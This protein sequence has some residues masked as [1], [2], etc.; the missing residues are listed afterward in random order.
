MTTGAQ[1]TTFITGLNGGASID[2]TLL[3]VLVST[4][5]AILEAERPWMPLRKMNTAL[6][7][8][9]SNTWQTAKA[10][11]SI[12]DFSRFYGDGFITLYDGSNARH[13]YRQVPADRQLEYKDDNTA[14]WYDVNGASI[15]F[16]GTPP[17]AG[18]LY[19]PYIANS[20][21]IDLASEIAVWSIFPSRFLPI[22]GFY[23][24]GMH[25]G[26][27]DYDDINARM[28]PENRA[29]LS[30]LKDAMETWDNELQLS[31]LAFNDPSELYSYPRNGAIDRS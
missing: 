19:L 11:S 1:L 22:L 24:V 28:L 30:A 5:K 26:A 13:Y 9:T 4:G 23:A 15:Y 8:A 3:D 29:V 17:Y 7:L 27:V 6:T 31:S 25:K 10:L 20:T 2:T 16:G 14:F 12:T 21:E 18:T